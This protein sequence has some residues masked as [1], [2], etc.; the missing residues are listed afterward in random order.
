MTGALMYFAVSIQPWKA[1]APNKAVG[2]LESCSDLH[3]F[4]GNG[5]PPSPWPGTHP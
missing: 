5:M 4:L 1:L 2:A 3:L